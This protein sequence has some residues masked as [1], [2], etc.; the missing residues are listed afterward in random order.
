MSSSELGLRLRRAREARDLSFRDLR[1]K[2]GLALSH[3][4]RL[5][6]GVVSSPEPATL[7]KL[8]VAL[9]VPY[10][11]LMRLAGHL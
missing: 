1:D 9:D 5:E 6:R 3:L 11:E 4:Q 2:S 7:R 8:A 10:V